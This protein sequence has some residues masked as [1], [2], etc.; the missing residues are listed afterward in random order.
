[1]INIQNTWRKIVV[2]ND[3]KAFEIFFD[4]FYPKLFNFSLQYVKSPSGAEEVVSDVIYNLLKDKNRLGSVERINAYLFQSVKNKSLSWLRDQKKN[5]KF[6]RIEQAEDYI[7]DVST[8][9]EMLPMDRNVY[10]LLES[11]V[12]KLPDQRK[13]VY[14]L[15]REEG[16]LLDEVA[17]L[18]SISGRTVEKHLELAIKEL[19]Q[20]LKGYLQ[21]QRQHPKI[22]KLFP[23]NF[24]FFFF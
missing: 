11:A 12:E 3:Q 6:E 5:L 19:C 13:M 16:L 1:M 20:H 8:S 17:A 24:I 21:D 22:R 14:K 2:D 9:P 23:R 15:I 10:E 4:Y 18:L 7:L